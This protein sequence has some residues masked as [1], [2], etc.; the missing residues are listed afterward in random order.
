MFGILLDT[1]GRK[2]AEEANELLAGEMRGIPCR[3]FQHTGTKFQSGL[4]GVLPEQYGP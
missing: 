1:K 4:P 3:G 2:Q